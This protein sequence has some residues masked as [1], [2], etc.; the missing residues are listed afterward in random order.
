MKNI[1]LLFL[2]MN[3]FLNCQSAPK[4]V[5]TNAALEDKFE[6]IDHSFVTFNDILNKYNDS[7]IFINVWA[8]WCRDCI[9]SIPELKTF[10]KAH[11]EMIYVFLS[12]DKSKK[13]WKTSIERLKLQGDHY[14]M[15]SGKKGPLGTFL[16]LDWIPRYL[17]VD[18]QGEILVYRAIETSDKNLLNYLK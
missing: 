11:P 1:L 16:D 9:V 7:Y 14:Y 18:P 2:C 17:I 15:T 5:F 12:L 13:S 10:Q 4:K 8:S 3:T 6:K